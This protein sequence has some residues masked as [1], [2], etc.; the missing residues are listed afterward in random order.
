MKK[1]IIGAGF[2]ALLFMGAPAGA[3]PLIDTASSTDAS[4]ILVSGGC[5]PYAH[6]GPYGGC[7]PGGQDGVARCPYGYH[8]GPHGRA[9]FPNRY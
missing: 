5:G 1:I 6:R 2:A 7:Q 3:N 9:C 4:T 8:L